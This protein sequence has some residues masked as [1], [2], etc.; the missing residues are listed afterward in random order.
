MRSV[1][2]RA[3]LICAAGLVFAIP[4]FGED[5]PRTEVFGWV[6]WGRWWDNQGSPVGGVNGGAGIGRR[7]LPQ[8][9]IE[10]EV[11]AFSGT[12]GFPGPASPYRARG[13]HIMGNGLLYAFRTER[14][15]VFVLL[16]AGAAHSTTEIN[17]VDYHNILSASGLVANAGMGMKIF[18][19]K[20]VA[21]R[22]EI[23]LIAG[24]AGSSA[25]EP[26][27]AELRFSLGLGYHW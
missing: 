5:Y 6:G 4:L 17:F 24:S 10:G 11:N 9:A 1:T 3:M 2:G 19:G 27:S 18:I 20:H 13:V 22:P 14:T 25:I 7:L 23:R 21:L 15:Q 8:F 26:F 16:G 12:R